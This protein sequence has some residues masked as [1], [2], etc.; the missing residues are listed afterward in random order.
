MISKTGI[1]R[2]THIRIS[3]AMRGANAYRCSMTLVDFGL[4][5]CSGIG[6]K[7][8]F[9]SECVCVSL[10]WMCYTTQLG[11]SPYNRSKPRRETIRNYTESGV[12]LRH[13]AC[14]C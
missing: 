2:Y 14:E 11:R 8:E 1:V 5:G 3:H 6:V 9:F 12:G 13:M 10:T 4:F 7:C